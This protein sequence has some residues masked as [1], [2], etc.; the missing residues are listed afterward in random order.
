MSHMLLGAAVIGLIGFIFNSLLRRLEARI[1]RW[2][3][4]ARGS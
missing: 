3:I 2:R 4:D 1:L